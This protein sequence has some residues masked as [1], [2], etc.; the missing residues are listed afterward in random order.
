MCFVPD[1]LPLLFDLFMIV[2]QRCF[3][4]KFEFFVR[5]GNAAGTDAPAAC[6]LILHSVV[7]DAHFIQRDAD[8]VLP[9]VL[10]VIELA[11]IRH[12]HMH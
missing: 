8:A 1:I 11:R 5:R 6:R 2:L 3:P 4:L 9:E 10:K 7:N 12:K